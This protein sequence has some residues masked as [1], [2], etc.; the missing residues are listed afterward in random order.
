[1]GN[2]P[3][4][5]CK[6]WEETS[7][8]EKKGRAAL[9]L[10]MNTANKN[11]DYDE[12]TLDQRSYSTKGLRKKVRFQGGKVLLNVTTDGDA[13]NTRET[14]R[15]NDKSATWTR[16]TAAKGTTHDSHGTPTEDGYFP[17]LEKKGE[18]VSLVA[19]SL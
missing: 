15:K 19:P 5:F 1:V 8:C 9:L 18:G 2:S 13:R 12:K 14:T 11:N 10:P 17:C 6:H 3:K 4:S 16:G 7:F